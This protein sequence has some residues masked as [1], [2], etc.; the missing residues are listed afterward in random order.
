M[1]QVQWSYMPK[2]IHTYDIGLYRTYKWNG[3]KDIQHNN[4][5]RLFYMVLS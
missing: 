1:K 5:T 3:T 2:I 4:V